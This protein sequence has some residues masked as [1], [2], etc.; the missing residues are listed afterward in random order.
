MSSMYSFPISEMRNKRLAQSTTPTIGN[1]ETIVVASIN[2]YLWP[3]HLLYDNIR[4]Q[5]F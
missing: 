5:I 3:E 4:D 1:K 2:I